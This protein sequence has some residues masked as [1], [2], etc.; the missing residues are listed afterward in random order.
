MIEGLAGRSGLQGTDAT[1]LV[2]A[3]KKGAD[4]DLLLFAA[5]QER[6]LPVVKI[7]VEQG[8]AN[9][10]AAHK[11]P[12]SQTVAVATD[13]AYDRFNSQ[14]NEYL[15]SK[16]MDINA[17]NDSGSTPLMRSVVD[18]NYSKVM[19][20]LGHGADPMIADNRG[21]FPLKVLQKEDYYG[22]FGERR[23]E[24]LKAMLKN[25]PDDTPQQ[26]PKDAF[27]TVATEAIEVSHPIELKKKPEG[28]P[29][30]P[31]KGFQL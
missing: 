19:H 2:L 27:N 21:Q 24:M 29:G 26:Q 23:S 3:L 6:A 5:I 1:L 22:N 15:L 4:P 30:H 14:I 10:N 20:Y 28:Q 25:V 13:W 8:G 11:L 9:V 16:G 18:Q 7:A 12:G 31:T 17:R